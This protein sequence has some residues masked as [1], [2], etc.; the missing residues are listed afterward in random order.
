MA[1]FARLLGFGI[2]LFPILGWASAGYAQ[3]WSGPPQPPSQADIQQSQELYRQG[4]AEIR[5]GKT[6]S[7]LDLLERSYRKSGAALPLYGIGLTLFHAGDMAKAHAALTQ[8]LTRHRDLPADLMGEARRM[9]EKAAQ[10][11][12]I[13]S[14]TDLPHPSEDPLSLDLDGEGLLDGGGRPLLLG[15]TPGP[16]VLR[17]ALEDH[18]PFEWRGEIAAGEHITIRPHFAPDEDTLWDSPWFWAIT[19]GVV[20]GAAAVGLA[21]GLGGEEGPSCGPTCLTL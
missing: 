7:G 17:L 11:L 16:H 14:V 15:V 8:L 18:E 10:S 6:E 19:G 21:V 12:G 1:R 20:I 5:D 4:A 3:G 2:I 9:R 13:L